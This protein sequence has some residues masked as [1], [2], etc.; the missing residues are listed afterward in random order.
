MLIVLI[1]TGALTVSVTVCVTPLSA[2]A[3][4]VAVPLPTADILPL[5]SILITDMS[6]D[7]QVIFL[8]SALSGEITA[9]A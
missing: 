8:F 9:A 5:L 7:S 3:V 1:W 2:L 6:S 4:I